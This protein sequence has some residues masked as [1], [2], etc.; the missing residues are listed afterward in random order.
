M[1]GKGI[2]NTP[3]KLNVPLSKTNPNR[4]NLALKEQRRKCPE[5]GKKILKMREQIN[6]I[7]VEVTPVLKGDVH[8]LLEN[9]LEVV[10][11]FMKLFWKEQKKYLSINP[12]PRKYH[13]MIIRSC[14]LLAAKSPSAYDELRNSN[15]LILHSTGTLRD[16]KNA[17][18]SHTGFK[19]S[20]ID[21][22]IKIASPLKSYQR[23]AVLP[24]DE[25][26]TQQNLIFD[27]YTGIWIGYVD[28]GDI[29]L[30]YRSF[31]D[32]NDLATHEIV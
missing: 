26:K 5:L 9:N 27:K 25:I 4:V 14:L 8:D 1:K 23:C 22:L 18:L 29:D 12:K 10:S 11:S 17:I 21:E 16:Y 15:I 24:F 13:P 7:G 28:L 32:V 6:S 30:N 31:Q 2:G 3:A 19:S 20:V